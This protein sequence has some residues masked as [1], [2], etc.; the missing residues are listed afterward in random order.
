M[1]SVKRLNG[2]D[3]VVN[4]ELIEFL[5]ET[6]DTVITL[7]SGNK[8]VVTDSVDEVIKKIKEYKRSINCVVHFKKQQKERK[9]KE[10]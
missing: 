4:C 10:S 9:K 6:P 2:K 3:F 5:E 8:L 1:I 7:I